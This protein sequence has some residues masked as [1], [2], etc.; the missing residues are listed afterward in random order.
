M[1]HGQSTPRHKN[2][3]D[4]HRSSTLSPRLWLMYIDGDGLGYGP[5]FGFQTPWLHCTML[6]ISQCTDLDSDPYSLFLCRTGIRV[7]V[8]TEFVS[9]N[10]NES[11]WLNDIDGY[12]FPY[13]AEIG[14]GDLSLNLYNV[15]IFCI[16]QC[17]HQV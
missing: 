17:N 16:V 4:N 15:N 3:A 12:G 13:Y 1:R 5:G 10:G 9:R 7:R 6:N 8:C 2:H 11:L 14:S